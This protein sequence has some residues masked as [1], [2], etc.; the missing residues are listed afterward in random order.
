MHENLPLYH[1]LNHKEAVHIFKISSIRSTLTIRLLISYIYIY[2]EHLFLM[3]LYHT[4]RSTTV[5]R[6][7]PDE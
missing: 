2:M 4:Q 6:T 5:G 7:P 3:F 1:I